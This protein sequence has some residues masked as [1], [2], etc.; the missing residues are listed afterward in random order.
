MGYFYRK[1]RIIIR[2]VGE[3]FRILSDAV[4]RARKSGYNK[5]NTICPMKG[6][7][8]A[9]N[10]Y[11]TIFTPADMLLPHDPARFAVIA[12]DQFT[13]APEYW[14]ACRT[15]I[16]SAP[17]AL[18]YILPEAYL[19]TPA[20]ATQKEWIREHMCDF[21]P[22]AMVAYSGLVY[23]ER[24]LPDGSIR[25]GVV[26]KLDLEAYDYAK[27]SH[28]PIRATEETVLE[29]IPPRCKVREE[30]AIEL[31]HILIL[32]DEEPLF[33]YLSVM[34]PLLDTLYDCDLMEGGG[35]IRGY[36]VTGEVLV[37]VMDRIAAY[38]TAHKD[39]VVYAM[40]DGN[41]SLAAAKAHYENLKKALGDAA[42]EHPA[43]YALCEITG[44]SEP[45]LVFEPIYRVLTGCDPADVLDALGKITAPG[46][47]G[48]T[49]HV[50]C[51]DRVE[52]VHF[53]AP[54]HALTVGSLQD[55][56]DGYRKT[57]PETNCDYIHGE[58]AL[59]SLAKEAHTV[60][61]LFD[62]MA[63]EELFPYVAAHGTLPRKTFSMGEAK[64]KRYYLEARV[65]R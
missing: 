12:C 50:L 54:T 55:F 60:G 28:S 56:L 58:D 4:D 11:S 15:C 36:A 24:I 48:E 44:L 51:G 2:N 62:G 19:G 26:G 17:S 38:E 52:T 5:Y 14:D 47:G 3:F 6:Y 20:E 29:R 35:H 30:A 40:G 34:R 39:G 7:P 27:D 9:M 23:V 10:N 59:R 37:W 13:S 65:I 46:H 57:H 63:K 64:S 21:T 32:V 18:D 53:T 43:R 45:S 42:K 33:A 49:I 41:H 1:K 22:D 31:P 25:Y 61:F 8:S 16:G